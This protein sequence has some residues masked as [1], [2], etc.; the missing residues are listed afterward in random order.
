VSHKN[1]LLARLPPAALE[2]I[3]PHFSIVPIEVGDEIAEPHE[4]VH[5]VYFPHSGVLSCVVDLAG[6]GAIETGMVGKDG[7][8]GGAQALDSKI[9]LNRVSAQLSGEASI[10]DPRKLCELALAYPSIREALLKYEQ[11]FLAQV[12][13]SVACNA[14]HSVRQRMARRLL[15]LHALGGPDLQLT[16]E[17][18][19]QMMGVRRPSVTQVAKEFQASGLITYRRGHISIKNIAKLRE[20]A[21]ECEDDLKRHYDWLYGADV[22]TKSSW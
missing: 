2:A 22:E 13:Q 18:L 9:S 14:V 5:R 1:E 3:L 6:G 10:I 11:L 15:R 17:F 16:Q 8:F 20:W 4:A 12:Q 21:C 19:A 7:A